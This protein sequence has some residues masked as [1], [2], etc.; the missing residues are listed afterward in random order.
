MSSSSRGSPRAPSTSHQPR[1]LPPLVRLAGALGIRMRG[2][3][4]PYPHDVLDHRFVSVDASDVFVRR[5]GWSG[6]HSDHVRPESA[7]LLLSLADHA[8]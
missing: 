6:A 1:G 2:P 8:W 3:A 7:H 4:E 5:R